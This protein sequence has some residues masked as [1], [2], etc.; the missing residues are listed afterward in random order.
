MVMP[1]G[2][3]CW[4]GAGRIAVDLSD[5]AIRYIGSASVTFAAGE[6]TKDV[7][8]PGIT[9]AGS[10]ISIL[11]SYDLVSNEYYCRAYDGGFTVFYLPTTG[12]PGFTFTVEVY[13]FQ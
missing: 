11:T 9:Q 2:L 13:N 5:Y 4:D 3:Q 6:M 1:Q 8:F 10:F 7:S 12:S